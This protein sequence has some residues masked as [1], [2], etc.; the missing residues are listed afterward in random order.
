MKESIKSFLNKLLFLSIILFIFSCGEDDKNANDP[1]LGYY[2]ISKSVLTSECSSQD[3]AVTLP[4]GTDVTAEILNAFLSDIVC[5]ST[6][7]KAIE[8]SDNGKIFFVCRVEGKKQ[9]QGTWA[10]NAERTELTLTLVIQGSPI[11]LK[12]TGFTESSTK[13]SGNV[14]SI[15]VPPLLL[16]TVES[17][18]SGVTDQAILI[19][20]DIDLEKLN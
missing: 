12:L 16:S 20:I 15:P 5:T 7:D 9:D 19:S 3:G 4:A 17:L 1:L 14:A 8:I 6:T 10:I 11:P 2:T 13:I 18:F